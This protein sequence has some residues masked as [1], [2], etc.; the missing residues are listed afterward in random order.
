MGICKLKTFKGDGFCDDGNN[1]AGCNWD[2]GDCCSGSKKYC[3][4]CK[5]KDCKF[6]FKSDTCVKQAKGS[7]GA[8]AYKG[9]GFCDDSNNNAACNWDKGDCCGSSGKAS[10]Y[11]YCKACKCL[12]CT[13]KK[14]DP[15]VTKFLKKCGA[16]AYQGDGFCDDSNNNGACSWDGGDCCGSSGKSNQFKFCKNCK[17]LDC[18]N[19]CPA[20]KKNV[21]R[22]KCGAGPYVGDGFCDDE[23]NN[24]GCAWDKGDCCGSSS[25]PNQYKLCK[26]CVCSNPVHKRFGINGFTGTKG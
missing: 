1:N 16:A 7:C 18:T 8:K 21:A 13:K 17:C 19:V 5:C 14:K 15:C 20:D 12:D 4:D 24:C 22:K 9:D 26:V 2:A 6:V 10:Q 23:N 25:K 11:K 3:K